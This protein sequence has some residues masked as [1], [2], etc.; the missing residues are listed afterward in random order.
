[1]TRT[2]KKRKRVQLAIEIDRTLR[3]S[4][5]RRARVEQRTVRSVVIR[6]LNLYLVTVPAD[7]QVPA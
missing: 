5:T 2:Q 1:M 7:R 6:A 4:L 3:A